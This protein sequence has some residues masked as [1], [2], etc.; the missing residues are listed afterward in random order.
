MTDIS[1]IKLKLETDNILLIK[2]NITKKELVKKLVGCICEKNPSLNSEEMLGAVLKRE[3]G[4]STTLESALSIP[5][6]RVEDLNTFLAAMAVMAKP[7]EDDYG[8]PIKVMFLFFSPAGQPYF[9]QHLKMLAHLAEKFTP[10]FVQEL[11][12]CA[13]P[14]EIA[15]KINL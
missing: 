4:I 1:D 9:A 7:I 10:E 5:H 6:A 8:L 3:E 13:T 2:E 12:T 14:Q 15:K 11:T